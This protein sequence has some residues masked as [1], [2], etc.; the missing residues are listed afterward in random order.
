MAKITLIGKPG[1][2][3]D[4]QATM[5]V[6]VTTDERGTVLAVSTIDMHKRVGSRK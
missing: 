4:F 2:L 6:L 5:P 1:R 3:E